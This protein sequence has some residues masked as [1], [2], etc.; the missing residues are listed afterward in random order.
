MFGVSVTVPT[1][2]PPAGESDSHGALSDA[3]QLSEP[4]PA[5][6]TSSV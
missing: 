6:E 4:P 2:V 3:V 5:F 1:F